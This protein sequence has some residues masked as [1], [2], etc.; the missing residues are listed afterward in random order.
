MIESKPEASELTLSAHEGVPATC[1]L[2]VQ[3]GLLLKN[4]AGLVAPA[5]LRSHL[6]TLMRTFPLAVIA[7]VGWTVTVSVADAPTI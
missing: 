7:L 3:V 6:G 5:E 4:E 2:Q 1:A